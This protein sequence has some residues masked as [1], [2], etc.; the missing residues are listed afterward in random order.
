MFRA[1]SKAPSLSTSVVRQSIAQ[2]SA[3]PCTTSIF[4]F[5]SSITSTLQMITRRWK[6]TY[7]REYQVCRPIL[8]PLHLLTISAQYNQAQEEVRLPRQDDRQRRTKGDCAAEGEGSMV[9]VSLTSYTFFDGTGYTEG[10]TMYAVATQSN[11]NLF[12]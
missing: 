8:E 2:S 3:Q 1:L 11:H 5:Q 10:S 12:D 6:G 7:G 4:S 9:S